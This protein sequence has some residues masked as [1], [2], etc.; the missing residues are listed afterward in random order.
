MGNIVNLYWIRHPDHTDIF[1]QGYVG[2]S[3]DAK[4]RFGQHY[5]RTQNRHLKFAIQKYGWDNLVKQQILV[6]DEAY[7]LDIEQKLRPT[8]AIGWNCAI[9]GGMPPN[10]KGKKFGPVS[11][12]TR[13]KMSALKVGTK[14]S[15]ET[16]KKRSLALV[17][18]KHQNITC[19]HCQTVG[20]ITTMKRWHFD[21]CTGQ[22]G[23]F[24]ARVTYNGKRKHLGY[25]L[26]QQ[27]ADQK[28]IDFYASV[29]KSLPKEFIRN[30]GL[31]SCHSF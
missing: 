14:Q 4:K 11:E 12:K 23:K 3:M 1:S 22:K 17:G 28:C 26:T 2:V 7:C 5:K 10:S 18:F 29:N 6:A 16:K 21:N 8:N 15:D 20:G 31:Q 19:P 30:K 25:F 27:E 13:A 24:K 9:G